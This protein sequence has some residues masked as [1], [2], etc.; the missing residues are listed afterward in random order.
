MLR[1]RILRKIYFTSLI[2]FVL[3]VI[4]SFTINKSIPNIKVEYQNKVSSIYL[5]DDNNK[6]N[7]ITKEGYVVLDKTCFYATGGG[8]VNDTGIISSNTFKARVVDVFRGPNGQN[9]H[10]V[11]VL[12]GILKEGECDLTLDYERRKSKIFNCVADLIIT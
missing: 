11:K 4:S 1:A 5:M 8:Q 2:V 7:K 6:V 12:S 9:I 10:K 3:F